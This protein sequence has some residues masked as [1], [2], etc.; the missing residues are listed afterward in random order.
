MIHSLNVHG[1]RTPRQT[2]QETIREVYY[3]S[4]PLNQ[5]STVQRVQPPSHF[6]RYV[7]DRFTGALQHEFRYK[8]A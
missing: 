5:T 8:Y 3:F 6:S 4:Y 1:F 7:P 2:S